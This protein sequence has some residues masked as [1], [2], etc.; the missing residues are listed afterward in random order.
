MA[1]F[2]PISWL[3]SC[4]TCT[5]VSFLVAGTVCPDALKSSCAVL[6]DAN[7]L[8]LTKVQSTPE[9]CNQT[10][11]S[12]PMPQLHHWFLCLSIFSTS[13]SY[14]LRSSLADWY[15]HMWAEVI[16]QW[17]AWFTILSPC[18]PTLPPSS[19]CHAII[20]LYC[21]SSYSASSPS[22]L[23]QPPR[24]TSSPSLLPSLL[25]QPPHSTSSPSPLTQPPHPASS[26]SLSSH[27]RYDGFDLECSITIHYQ[28]PL[29]ESEST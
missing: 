6:H 15:L 24:S 9:Y 11:L 17:S 1:D 29:S 19:P 22:L 3:E 18:L 16:S 10:R 7:C 5:S 21:L 14:E 28:L 25:T 4:N 2:W 20:S 12:K 8:Y 23:T 26:P 13:A 27:I